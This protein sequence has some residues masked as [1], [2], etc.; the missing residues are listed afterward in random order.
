MQFLVE[1][2]KKLKSNS[3]DIEERLYKL[4][5]ETLSML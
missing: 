2:M 5:T 4:L 1:Q 3:D